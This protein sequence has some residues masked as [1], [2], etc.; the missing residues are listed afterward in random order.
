LNATRDTIL[1]VNVIGMALGLATSILM[2]MYVQHEW[3]YDAFHSQA[4]EI[5]RLYRVE[6]RVRTPL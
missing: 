1:F 4:D 5:F 6:H 3:T 2:L